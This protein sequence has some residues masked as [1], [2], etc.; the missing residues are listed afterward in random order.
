MYSGLAGTSPRS[1]LG[2]NSSWPAVQRFEQLFGQS[3]SKS[4]PTQ[5]PNNL[6]SIPFRAAS[7]ELDFSK[8][9]LDR[10]Q[11]AIDLIPIIKKIDFLAAL[12]I[13]PE[14]VAKESDYF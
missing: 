12:Q 11:K 4:F 2:G 5:F 14:L 6:S 13:A 1:C 3:T 8:E 10:L 7:R 9:S